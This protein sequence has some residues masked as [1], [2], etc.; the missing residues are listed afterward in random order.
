MNW[1]VVG[2]IGEV[3]G[4]IAVVATLVYL[5]K[6]IRI[7]AEA[8]KA[9]VRQGVTDA[10]VA[11]LALEIDPREPSSYPESRRHGRPR[12]D[13]CSPRGARPGILRA[14]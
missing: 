4:A 6:Q 5:A 12:P 8:T 9:M 13:G 1:A 10:S 11:Y 2:A 7:S 14:A 3:G